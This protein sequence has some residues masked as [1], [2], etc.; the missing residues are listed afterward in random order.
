M[1][2]CRFCFEDDRDLLMDIKAMISL[3][4]VPSSIITVYGRVVVKSTVIH[5]VLDYMSR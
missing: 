4:K 5:R 1:Q 3:E 2:I